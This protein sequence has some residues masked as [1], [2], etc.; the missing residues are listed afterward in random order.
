MT[1]SKESIQEKIRTDVRWTIRTIEILFDRQTTDEQ[2]YGQTYVRNGRGF[3][4][5]DSEIFTSFYHQIQ[6]R[7]RV[8]SSGGQLVNFQSLLSD[9][10]LEICQKHLPKYWGQVLEEIENRKG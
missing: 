10:Q 5:R 6:K 2:R 7:K 8:V 9:K 3:N 1:Y 4:G